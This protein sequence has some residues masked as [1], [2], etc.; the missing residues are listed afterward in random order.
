MHIHYLALELVLRFQRR[1]DMLP[2]YMPSES[3]KWC[4]MAQY[5]LYIQQEYKVKHSQPYYQE[6]LCNGYGYWSWE[7]PQ[8]GCAELLFTLQAAM[9]SGH[10]KHCS[11]CVASFFDHF[12][13]QPLHTIAYHYI[14][15][16]CGH[17]DLFFV[18]IGG[19]LWNKVHR[20][21]PWPF[22]G[23]GATL[24]LD[25][26]G[27]THVGIRGNCALLWQYGTSA[28]FFDQN[29]WDAYTLKFRA[30]LNGGFPKWGY[31]WI[32]LMLG[33]SILNQLLG[34]PGSPI[35]TEFSTR[36][37]D[38]GPY[39]GTHCGGS[40]SWAAPSAFCSA[41]D[42]TRLFARAVRCGLTSRWATKD[43]S[44]A[45]G[46]WM[47]PLVLIGYTPQVSYGWFYYVLLR[48]YS[49]PAVTYIFVVTCRLFVTET[50]CNWGWMW[51]DAREFG[52]C[53]AICYS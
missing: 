10:H 32:H 4:W 37:H 27:G 41:M 52:G 39:D 49:F 40:A 18:D 46:Q 12:Q 31:P 43:P 2:E 28:G 9:F 5:I 47:Y 34:I 16:L 48:F 22:D 53:A 33:F 17:I 7:Q 29:L 14:P 38:I 36:S 45:K 30:V 51:S 24:R 8:H 50:G 21:H 23:A 20:D 35:G 26:I 1:L 42:F 15:L 13:Q 6:S 11:Y 25:W 3:R 19:K 44:W